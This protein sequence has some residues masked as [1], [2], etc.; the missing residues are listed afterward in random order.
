MLLPQ[1]RLVHAIA[2]DSS[3]GGMDRKSHSATAPTF[4]ANVYFRPKADIGVRASCALRAA[5]RGPFS[6]GHMHARPN[7]A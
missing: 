4:F 6:R 1:T 3:H 7:Q 2:E 5:E